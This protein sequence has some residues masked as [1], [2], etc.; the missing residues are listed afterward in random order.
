MGTA[1]LGV[2]GGRRTRLVA[3]AVVAAVLVALLPPAAGTASSAGNGR[4]SV[5]VQA[6]PGSVASAALL[7]TQVGGQVG[8]HLGVINGFTAV[9]PAGQV[10]RLQRSPAVSSVAGNEPVQMQAATYTRPPTPGRCTA[11]P[12]RPAPR[13]TGRPAT[14]A[15]AWTWP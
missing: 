8:R 3:M 1:G 9:V 10:E 11:P 5:I 4:R 14:P 7:V 12:W 15:R 2:L 13:P 6:T